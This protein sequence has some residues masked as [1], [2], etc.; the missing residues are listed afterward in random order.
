MTGLAL[1]LVDGLRAEGT[2]PTGRAP[3]LELDTLAA[4]QHGHTRSPVDALARLALRGHLA[5]CRTC[6]ERT[7]W[8]N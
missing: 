3:A 2:A 4:V 1:T 8:F 5:A 7:E 6:R